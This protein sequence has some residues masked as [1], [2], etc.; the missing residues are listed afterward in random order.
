MTATHIP[1]VSKAELKD[2]AHEH[3]RG[4]ENSLLPSFTPDLE[5]LDEEGVRLDVRTN[6]QH[7]FFS[8]FCAGVG[9]RDSAER[10]RFLEVAVDE[11]QGQILV[12][13]GGGSVSTL[14]AAVA[15]LQELQS[16]GLSHV[17]YSLPSGEG[18]ETA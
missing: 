2:W 16:L 12:S 3:F 11:A 4:G 9:L 10:R 14:E 7:G 5:S 6:I 15:N 17:M 8:M 1:R 18:F 13:S